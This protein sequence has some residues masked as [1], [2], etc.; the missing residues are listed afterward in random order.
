L[1]VIIISHSKKK[2]QCQF[3]FACVV[4]TPMGHG[5]NHVTVKIKDDLTE[6]LGASQVTRIISDQNLPTLVRQLALHANVSK[7]R[8][9]KGVL[10]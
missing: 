10:L 6:H 5:T 1:V 2:F 7:R 3:M 8:D 9:F 4:V